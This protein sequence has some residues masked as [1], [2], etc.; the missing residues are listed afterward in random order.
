M[1]WN[2]DKSRAI[3][4]QLCQQLCARIAAGEYVPHQR[5]MSVRETALSAGVNPN[6]VQRAFAQLEQQGILYS[7]RGAGWFVSGN[8]D[9]ARQLFQSLI[10]EKLDA[11]FHEMTSLGLTAEAVKEYVKEW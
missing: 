11:F 9:A 6:T 4:P 1:T 7:E 5:I 10:Q 2:L 3:C 8:T